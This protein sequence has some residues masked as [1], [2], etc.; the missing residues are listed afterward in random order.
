MNE[1]KW[2]GSTYNSSFFI[3]PTI[4]IGRWHTTGDISDWRCRTSETYTGVT[5]YWLHF[6]AGFTVIRK[7]R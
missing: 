5:F 6:R 2:E 1:I 3:F 4:G 7:R